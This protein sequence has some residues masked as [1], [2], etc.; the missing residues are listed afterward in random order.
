[1][2]AADWPG[3]SPLPHAGFQA[4][5]RIA[6]CGCMANWDAPPNPPVR[7]TWLVHP[8]PVASGGVSACCLRAGIPVASLGR[9]L[10]DSRWHRRF[11]FFCNGPWGASRCFFQEGGPGAQK[12]DPYR[13][14]PRITKGL[15]DASP[16]CFYCA[17]FSY[18]T[19]PRARPRQRARVPPR[20]HKKTLIFR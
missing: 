20:C 6:D 11:F 13:A 3:P 14:W 4:I 17:P 15:R 12:K 7:C 5:G 10:L 2:T 18:K 8:P 19:S 1:M 16:F 9:R